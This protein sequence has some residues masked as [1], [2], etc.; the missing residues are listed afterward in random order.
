MQ[1]KCVRKT[2][3]VFF[4]GREIISGKAT[5]AKQTRSIITGLPVANDVGFKR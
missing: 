4:G 2:G 3:A 1:T 5:R